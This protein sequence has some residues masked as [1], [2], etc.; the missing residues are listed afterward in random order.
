MVLLSAV[1]HS[2]WNILTQTSKNTRF[3]S[4][5]K[6]AWLI[7]LA[8]PF[9]IYYEFSKIPNLILVLGVASG[10]IHG[11][12]IYCLSKAYQEADLSYVY[13]IARSAPVFVPAFAF[14]FLGEVLS[15]LNSLG[16][17]L[18]LISIYVLHFDGH[19]IRG[20]GNLLN[21]IKDKGLRWS[22][23]TLGTV[24]SY[25]IFDKFA[26][27]RFFDLSPETSFSNGIVFFLLEASFCFIFYNIQL[28]WSYPFKEIKS[29]WLAE[30]A[31][32][33]LGAFAT[34]GSYGLICVVFQ[35]EQVGLVVALRQTSVLI[36][37]GWGCFRLK[38]S[39]GRE[40]MIAATMT[41]I[42][43]ACASW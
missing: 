21:A 26:M 2:L 37:V 16:I 9:F 12:Y 35:H 1:S 11:I 19:L 14:L 29:V 20:A 10:A 7:L 38:E 8:I 39:F 5:L 13:P 36:V 15:G 28:F 33:L 24:V 42:G 22:F 43:V 18:I 27:N 32:G 31:K 3:F 17:V 6:G 4:G 25:S 34:L 40:R 30:W 41:M 23:F